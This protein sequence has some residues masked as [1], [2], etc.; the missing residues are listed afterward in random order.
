MDDTTRILAGDCTVTYDGTD[1]VTQRGAVLIL[2]KPDDTVLVH[3]ADGYQPAAWLTRA[4]TVRVTRTD[5]GFELFATKDDATLH[6]ESHTTTGDRYYPSSPAG[7]PTGACPTCPGTLIE[8]TAA[9]VCTACRHQYQIPRDATIADDPCPDCGLPLMTVERGA[10]FELCTDHSCDAL[11]DVVA[12]QFDTAWPC[13]NCGSPTTIDDTRGVCATCTACDTTVSV[14]RGTIIGEC[15]C[16]M[17][18]FASAD[19]TRCF[20]PDCTRRRETAP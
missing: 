13:P 7:P 8:T 11:A 3:D 9:I 5:D 20:D 4:D 2:Y 19:A 6:I 14:P 10:T 17:P 16:G 1:T 12:D 15:P 18:L